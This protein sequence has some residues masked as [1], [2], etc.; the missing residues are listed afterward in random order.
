MDFL[1]KNTFRTK[2]RVRWADETSN[3]PL[4]IVHQIES[5]ESRLQE[6]A[7]E[8]SD[9][10]EDEDETEDEAIQEEEIVDRATKYAVASSLGGEAF[11]GKSL[12]EEMMKTDMSRRGPIEEGYDEPFTD[13][14]SIVREAIPSSKE[15]VKIAVSSK[16]VEKD[17][18]HRKLAEALEELAVV[19]DELISANEKVSSQQKKI[20]EYESILKEKTEEIARYE[21]ELEEKNQMMQ[22]LIRKVGV[23]Q[24]SD[25]ISSAIGIRRSSDVTD[26]KGSITFRKDKNVREAMDSPRSVAATGG[27]SRLSDLKGPVRAPV[28]PVV[29]TAGAMDPPSVTKASTIKIGVN[30]L[31]ELKNR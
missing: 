15:N 18:V 7:E 17:D 13:T 12:L 22:M 27:H 2:A 29:K 25:G 21:K 11:P 30:R 4:E 24:Y 1:A 10:D 19:R 16:R 6:E 8:D 3:R 26:I 20:L 5:L 9:V 14:S 31:E 23:P 28:I